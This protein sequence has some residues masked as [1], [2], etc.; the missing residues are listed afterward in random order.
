MWGTSGT[1]I[2]CIGRNG[3]IY[4]YD[5]STWQKLA[6]GTTVDIQDIWGEG[7]TVLAVASLLNYGRGLDLLKIDGLSV[8]KLDTSGLPP[9]LN[10]IWFDLDKRFYVTGNGV[11]IKNNLAEARWQSENTHPLLY[12]DRIRGVRWNDVFIAGSGGL[13]VAF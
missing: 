8:T 1:N 6:S 4:H 12:K 7:Q 9:S 13:G 11:Y 10:G 2:Y 3:A 5:G